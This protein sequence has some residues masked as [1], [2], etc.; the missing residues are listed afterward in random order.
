MAQ[1]DPGG[2]VVG[3]GSAA[4]AHRAPIGHTV[5]ALR[6]ATDHQPGAHASAV[7]LDA[8]AGPGG[9]EE[10]IKRRHTKRQ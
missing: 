7:P 8:P 6:P 2:H 3:T 1:Y 10:G 4:V 9:G 5:G